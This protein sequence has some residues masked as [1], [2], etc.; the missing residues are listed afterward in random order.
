MNLL[1]AYRNLLFIS[2]IFC[3]CACPGTADRQ[4]DG[5][6][7][8]WSKPDSRRIIVDQKDSG[9]ITSSDGAGADKTV[10]LS[11]LAQSFLTT[12]ATCPS[13][14]KN[15][16]GATEDLLFA[17]GAVTL[18]AAPTETKNWVGNKTSLVI[19]WA[20]TDCDDSKPL[21]SHGGLL[22]RGAKYRDSTTADLP[23]NLTI[24]D[25]DLIDINKDGTWEAD[26]GTPRPDFAL[27]DDS[28]L[29]TTYSA[30]APLADKA[31]QT[32]AAVATAN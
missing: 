24:N 22:V 8:G 12:A 17:D 28:Q 15:L 3:L 27:P 20:I 31:K 10:T 6:G 26:N 1:R 30:M 9:Q 7:G 14:T 13:K 23:R 2:L 19:V 21:G 32:I 18:A 4:F 11:N 29:A 25:I 16:I 5:S